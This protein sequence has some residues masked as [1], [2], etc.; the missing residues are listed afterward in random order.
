MTSNKSS[1]QQEK[2]GSVYFSRASPFLQ[3]IHVQDNCI[4]KL[5][6]LRKKSLLQLKN[7]V[8]G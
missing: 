3:S 7:C 6:F 8:V 4:S 1:K 2:G 5:F